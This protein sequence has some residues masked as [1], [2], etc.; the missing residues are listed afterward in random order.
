MRR[1]RTARHVVQHGE[2]GAAAESPTPKTRRTSAKSLTPRRIVFTSS[3]IFISVFLRCRLS[4][5][6]GIGFWTSLWITY[7]GS[8][9]RGTD[10]DAVVI[11]T[12]VQ[13]WTAF[14]V[15]KWRER[16]AV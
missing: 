3:L 15:G 16:D 7:L 6:Y 4:V 11:A 8:I 12:W 10:K 14:T 9:G 13:T 5:F 1:E 2:P